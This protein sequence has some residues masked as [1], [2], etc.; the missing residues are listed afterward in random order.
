L[1]Y[2]GYIAVAAAA[3]SAA[4]VAGRNKM[5]W[6]GVVVLASVTA[7]GG[8][9][10]R[11]VFLGHFPLAWV[12]NPALLIICLGAAF[13]T[14]AL[15]RFMPKLHYPFLVL[16]A[17]G[18]VVFTVIGCEVASSMGQTAIIVVVSGMVSGIVGGVLRDMLVNEVP[19]VFSSELYATVAIVA[20]TLYTLGIGFGWPEDWVALGTIIIGF[21]L[22]LLAIAFRLEMPKFIY[23]KDIR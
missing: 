3:I 17:F 6:F 7:L 10:V 8:G 12:A 20:G 15:A 1:S 16:D 18:L 5:D 11:D 9:T 22:R 13:A 4:L 21:A 23:D 2:A 19:L 14:I